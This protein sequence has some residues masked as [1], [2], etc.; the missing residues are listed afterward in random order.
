M[1]LSVGNIG[2]GRGGRPQKHKREALHRGQDEVKRYVLGKS[3]VCFL[4]EAAPPTAVRPAPRGQAFIVFGP[5]KETDPSRRKCKRTC[6][7]GGANCCFRFRFLGLF[8]N[9][10]F[11]W[12]NNTGQTEGTPVTTLALLSDGIEEG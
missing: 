2:R 10:G 1:V 3:K 8:P 4:R 9:N 5:D 11:G 6:S 7:R 12:V